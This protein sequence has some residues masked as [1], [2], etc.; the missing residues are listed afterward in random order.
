V[1]D[2]VFVAPGLRERP[3]P[4]LPRAYVRGAVRHPDHRTVFFHSWRLVVPNLEALEQPV[5][6]IAWVD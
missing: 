2:E 4:A 1:A 5:E 3:G 6:G